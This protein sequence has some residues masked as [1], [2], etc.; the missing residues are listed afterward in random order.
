VQHS[1]WVTGL[2]ALYPIGLG[3]L[4]VAYGLSRVRLNQALLIPAGL[5]AGAVVVYAQVM[6]ILAGGSLYTKTDHLLDRMYVWW[7]ALT[8]QGASVDPLPVIL[9]M[10]TATWVG[11]F[12]AAWAIFRWRNGPLGL[13]PGAAALIWDS[14]F[15]NSDFSISAVLYVIL[16][17]LLV[18]RL[19]V[20][21]V[22]G[23]WEREETPYPRF[24]ALSVLNVT[25]WATCALLAAASLLPV[26]A[27]SGPA[28]SGWSTLTGPLTSR[29]TPI[30]GAF[31][32]INPDKGLKIHALKDALIL[33]GGIDPSI[34]PAAQVEA[35][36]PPDVA[37]FLRDQSFD[38]YRRDGWSLS[39]QD[40]APLPAGESSA[41]ASPESIDPLARKNV[42]VQVRVQGGNGDRLLSVGQP[43]R[44]DEDARSISGADPADVSSLQAEDHLSNGTSYTVVGSVSAATIERLRAAGT[45]Y[46]DWVTQNYLQTSRRLPPRVGDKAREL[47]AGTANP[48]DAA[49]AIESYLRTFPEDYGVSPAPGRQDPVDYFLFDAQRGY[50][51]YYASAMTVML[52][53]LGIPARLAAG[54][55]ID[56]ARQD[57]DGGTYKL[58][59]AQAFAWPEVYFPSVGWVEFNPTPSQ[60]LVPR[61]SVAQSE[62]PMEPELTIAEGD[63]GNNYL[64]LRSLPGI[65]SVV[66]DAGWDVWRT[67]IL[68]SVSIAIAGTLLALAT[69]WELRVWGL[70]IEA[71][72]WEKSLALASL[73]HAGPR[74]HETPRDFAERLAASVPGT[75]G[76]VRLAAGYERARF[77]NRSASPGDVRS[78]RDAWA[79]TRVALLRRMLRVHDR[80]QPGIAR[81]DD[82]AV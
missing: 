44:S 18:M 75:A 66:P 45:A 69:A 59:Q 16:G 8:Q 4:A 34:I 11:S 53:T 54:Y 56:P 46:P 3:A 74:A 49:S 73:G 31:I 32:G 14:G 63:G 5:F 43:V 7:S 77:S 23:R 25:F 50:Y 61:P 67:A 12:I 33:Q 70:G 47:T 29:L 81:R 6:A 65:D 30:A 28:S 26:G 60:P 35:D 72:L 64:P 58:T 10:L 20:A 38:Q 15:S 57:G 52:R 17:V 19:R 76:I 51:D 55:V 40:D 21:S 42:A 36:L 13:I 62:P 80:R 24:I 71:K 68:V 22:Q 82:P 39:D 78:L 2:P 37:P 41:A 48:Y 79:S 27:Q 9:I 1:D